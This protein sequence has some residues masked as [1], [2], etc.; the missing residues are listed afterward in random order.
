MSSRPSSESRHRGNGDPHGALDGDRPR[1][2][3]LRG[4]PVYGYFFAC[5]ADKRTI[6]SPGSRTSRHPIGVRCSSPS[7]NRRFAALCRAD[8][9]EK[10]T[11][12]VAPGRLRQICDLL[13]VTPADM[14]DSPLKIDGE[15]IPVMT[16]WAY[17]TLSALDKIRSDRVR[18]S[19]GAL[20][21]E[22]AGG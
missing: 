13:G 4:G 2:S 17:R 8:R 19:I 16:P 14:F 15:P 22:L 1:L 5:F 9:Y 20:I 18:R 6:R 21:E 11:N 7:P 3:G 12:A 10:G